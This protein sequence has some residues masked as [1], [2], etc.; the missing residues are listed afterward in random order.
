MLEI[1]NIHSGYGRTE[2]LRGA[3]LSVEQGSLVSLIGKNGAGKS[4]LLK[5]VIGAHPISSGEIFIDGRAAAS[6]SRREIAGSVAYLSQERTVPNMTALALTVHGRYPHLGYCRSYSEED[7]RIAR[8]AM[9]R[10]G[11]EGLAD[12]PVASLSGGM[13]RLVYIAMA[14]AQ[15]TDYILLDEPLSHLDIAHQL[16]LMDILRSLAAEGRGIL[17]VM[18]DLPMAFSYSDKLAVLR[19]GV[20]AAEAPPEQIY[21]SDMVQRLFSAP[22]RRRGRG[23][24]Y[25]L[26]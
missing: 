11:I 6:L 23:Y 2:V 12:C 26:K 1:K 9:E 14:L 4:T 18:H 13:R 8:E 24:Y 5:T 25:S 20:I 7:Y 16:R 21:D 15:G 10:L 17:T 22:L 3:S 19:D